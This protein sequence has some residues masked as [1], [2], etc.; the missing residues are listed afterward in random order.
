[1]IEDV[2]PMRARV[3]HRVPDQC[4]CSVEYATAIAGLHGITQFQRESLPRVLDDVGHIFN[5]ATPWHAP[6]RYIVRS[7]TMGIVW[8]H[9]GCLLTTSSLPWPSKYSFHHIDIPLLLT[10]HPRC[11]VPSSCH[12]QVA[13]LQK[14]HRA[15]FAVA[16][17]RIPTAGAT[18]RGRTG[19]LARQTAY[20]SS[21]STLYGASPSK[22][23]MASPSLGGMSTNPKSGGALFSLPLVVYI[24]ILSLFF[25]RI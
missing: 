15:T 8:F 7:C 21:V 13:H 6:W 20:R 3:S 25:C 12:S 22:A 5:C 24:P 4:H 14:M 19:L 16:T 9:Q 23:S 2:C 1:M 18:S 11:A 10:H 17:P